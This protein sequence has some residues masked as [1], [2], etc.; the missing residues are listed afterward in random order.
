VI[1][2]TFTR[3]AFDACM[4]SGPIVSPASGESLD[5]L[6]AGIAAAKQVTLEFLESLTYIRDPWRCPFELLPDLERE[7]GISPNAALPERDRRAAVAVVRYKRRSLATIRKLQAVLDK[8]GFG[9][10]G[11]GLVVTPNSSPPADP[12]GIIGAFQL[13]AHEVGDGSGACAGNGGAYAAQRSGY[14]LVNGD[15]YQS[16]PIYPQAGT[17]CARA[18]DGSDTESPKTRAGYYTSYS[19]FS[20]TYASPP[21]GYWPLI[22][23][24]GGT[25]YR[26]PDGSISGISTAWVPFERRQELHR[27]I[28]RIKPEGM[29]AGMCV[30]YN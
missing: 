24:V 10:G 14:L 13:T 29:W 2:R 25:A 1:D 15:S 16:R 4:P 5:N 28:L 8:A 19:L 22:F 12:Q 27:L 3:E 30:Q 11:Y 6:L 26:N 9:A 20:D 17:F 18:F 21:E 23:F 7:F